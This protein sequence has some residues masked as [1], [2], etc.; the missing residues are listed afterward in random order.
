MKKRS[1]LHH[2]IEL[3]KKIIK[4]CKPLEKVL[5]IPFF[6]YYRVYPKENSFILLANNLALLEEYYTKIN[7]DTIYFK[8][9]LNVESKYKF[10]LW[11]EKPE[12]LAMNLYFN[13]NF[14]NGISVMYKYSGYI[15]FF[16][17]VSDRIN[18]KK[19]DFFIQNAGLL[20]RFIIEFKA[21][22]YNLLLNQITAAKTNYREISDFSLPQ[23]FENSENVAKVFLDLLGT[24]GR[25]L[26]VN[27]ELIKLTAREFKCLEMLNQGYSVK[28]IAKD[29]KISV[30]TV[31]A[32]INSIKIK[33]NSNN[34]DDLINILKKSI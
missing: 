20:E 10:I 7:Y 18:P 25:V 34:R 11:P 21:K 3:S 14:W 4:F 31:A 12:N 16:S 33:T 17:F 19:K 5:E 8:E 23:V 24:N 28:A 26:E 9:L 27:G 13:N 2:S 22:F 6:N 15:E 29:L 32:H 1:P 30:K